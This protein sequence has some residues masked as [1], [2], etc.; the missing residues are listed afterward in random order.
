VRTY[1]SF[2]TVLVV[3]SQ[4]FAHGKS[5]PQQHPKLVL[6]LVERSRFAAEKP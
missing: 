1:F 5:A 4:S 6:L 2:L 3:L